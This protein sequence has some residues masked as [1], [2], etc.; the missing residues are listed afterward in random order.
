MFSFSGSSIII[1]LSCRVQ[2]IK[3]F[4]HSS[5][6]LTWCLFWPWPCPRSG[7]VSNTSFRYPLSSSCFTFNTYLA[8]LMYRF[9]QIVASFLLI[10][11]NIW[12]A[13]FVPSFIKVKFYWF[14]YFSRL[15]NLCLSDWEP[16][17]KVLRYWYL[18][19]LMCVPTVK[20]R[21]RYG[22]RYSLLFWNLWLT[23]GGIWTLAALCWALFLVFKGNLSTEEIE[24][25][26]HEYVRHLA[27]EVVQEFNSL[28]D[29]AES[30][31][32]PGF[33]IHIWQ[34]PH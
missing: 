12:L 17:C 33:A 23:N 22:S 30:G 20:Y 26:G 5:S 18:V 13:V 10:K 15:K 31:T 6:V 27:G 29:S 19:M 21:S 24:L 9:V 4:D 34:L 3:L 16:S 25:W 11:N 2:L 14:V 7:T 1:I 32:A 28:P 8:Y